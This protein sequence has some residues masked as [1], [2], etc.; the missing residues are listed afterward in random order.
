[1]PAASDCQAGRSFDSTM[2]YRTPAP[3]WLS[4]LVACSPR[5][6]GR[7]SRTWDQEPSDLS[8]RHDEVDGDAEVHANCQYREGDPD[9]DRDHIRRDD[10]Q[11][12]SSLPLLLVVGLRR[13]KV[14]AVGILVQGESHEPDREQGE[15]V[16]A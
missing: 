7:G 5:W 10:G 15:P 14:L 11:K 2:I 1:M 9:E 8:E 12:L 3:R 6:S 4:V 13:V 16:H